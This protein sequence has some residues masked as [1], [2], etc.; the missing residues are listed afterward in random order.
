MKKKKSLLRGFT[1]LC[2]SSLHLLHLCV[3]FKPMK[4]ASMTN[5]Q[6]NSNKPEFEE[7]IISNCN[8]GRSI[9]LQKLLQDHANKLESF[10][11]RSGSM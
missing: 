2:R 3:M 1:F 6:G 11:K 4:Y 9:G 7:G 8:V 10:K 5:R